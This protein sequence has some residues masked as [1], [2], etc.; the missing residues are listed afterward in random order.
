MPQAVSPALTADA[1]T[2]IRIALGAFVVDQGE[3]RKYPNRVGVR[4]GTGS[5]KTMK[6][7]VA[8][9]MARPIG[10]SIHPDSGVD[11][12]DYAITPRGVLALVDQEA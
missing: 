1:R 3:D 7:L 9:G 10:M 5:A 4:Q 8:S 6:T 2:L 11:D 12:L